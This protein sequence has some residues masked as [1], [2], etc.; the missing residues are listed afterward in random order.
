M[1]P[2]HMPAEGSA[3]AST[4]RA[5]PDYQRGRDDNPVVIVLSAPGQREE[6]ANK[7]AA[8][9][10]GRTLSLALAEFHRRRPELFPSPEKDDYRIANA[11]TTVHYLAKTGRTEASDAELFS[12]RNLARLAADLAG[13]STIIALGG[14]ARAAVE[15]AGFT[16]RFSGPHPSMQFINRNYKVE[17]ATSGERAK[18]R[19]ARYVEALLASE[20]GA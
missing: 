2:D 8:G 3:I 20:A 17:G 5:T 10:T 6:L 13:K 16:P 9:Q 11:A 4:A 14:R 12:P 1:A 19:L 7:P 18:L 15:A